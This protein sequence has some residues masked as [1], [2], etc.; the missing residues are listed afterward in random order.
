LEILYHVTLLQCSSIWQRIKFQ[1]SCSHQF[2]KTHSVPLLDFPMKQ[3]Y[4]KRLFF[5]CRRNS[6]M[7][8]QFSQQY[9]KKYARGVP[10]NSRIA[11]RSVCAEGQY[12]DGDKVRF[13]TCPIYYK[14][15]TGAGNFLILPH[16]I[17][18]QPLAVLDSWCMLWLCACHVACYVSHS[19]TQ[20]GAQS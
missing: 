6:T 17:L 14:L 5:I 11:R 16:I 18:Y 12:V 8:E 2:Y 4:A 20:L 13:Y 19:T 3:H 9:Q 15:C 10:I 1:Q 7:R